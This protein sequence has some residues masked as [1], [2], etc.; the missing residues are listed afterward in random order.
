MTDKV[1]MC[2]CGKPLHYTDETAERLTRAR[3][4]K[5]GEFVK[6]YAGGRWWKVQRHYVSLHGL[7]AVDMP[8]L[9]FEDVTDE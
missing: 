8:S 1:E 5:L 2:H 3:V 7:R 9:G 4:A 6:I